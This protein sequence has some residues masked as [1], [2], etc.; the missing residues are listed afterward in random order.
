MRRESCRP[1]EGGAPPVDFGHGEEVREGPENPV[2]VP[3]PSHEPEGCLTECHVK[4]SLSLV[5]P[6]HS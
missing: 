5:V 6:E 2:V 4:P 3:I 1:S